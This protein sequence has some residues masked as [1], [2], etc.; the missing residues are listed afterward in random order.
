MIDPLIVTPIATIK[1]GSN[2]LDDVMSLSE[3]KFDQGHLAVLKQT[4]KHQKV[5]VAGIKK[6]IVEGFEEVTLWD[7]SGL[8]VA[9]VDVETSVVIT[10]MAL[11]SQTSTESMAKEITRLKQ[12]AAQF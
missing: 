11:A 4:P 1:P 12:S 8:D 9:R 6:P 5:L 10:G 3:Y 2:N 7:I